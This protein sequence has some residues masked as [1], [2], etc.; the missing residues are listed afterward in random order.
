MM[1]SAL[2]MSRVRRLAGLVLLA[3]VVLLLSACEP[4]DAR[5]ESL[6]GLEPQPPSADRLRELEQL[7]EEYGEV[8]AQRLDAG[9]RQADAMKLLAQEYMRQ[10]LYGP[11]YE[12]LVD[13]LLIQPENHVLSYLAGASSAVIGKSQADLNERDRYLRLSERHYLR[14]I[15]I[16]PGYTDARYGLAILYSFELEEPLNAINQLEPLIQR[17]ASNVSALFVLARSRVAL[18]QIDAAV[19]AYDQI[20]ELSPDRDERQRAERNRELLLGGGG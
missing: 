2:V 8:V 7:I 3:L 5:Y 17:N 16:Q 20:I 18:G 19:G 4:P 14:A 13:A 12:T 9:I 6:V 15:E 1:M 10:Q 11:A